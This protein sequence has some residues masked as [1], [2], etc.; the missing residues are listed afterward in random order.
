MLPGPLAMGHYNGQYAKQQVIFHRYIV[1]HLSMSAP[2]I[3]EDRKRAFASYTAM[4][5]SILQLFE[6]Q[7]DT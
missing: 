1:A 3:L 7:L 2:N 6:R 5:V 4:K